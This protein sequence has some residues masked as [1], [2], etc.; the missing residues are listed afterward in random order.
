MPKNSF[1]ELIINRALKT[2]TKRTVKKT[3]KPIKLKGKKREAPVVYDETIDMD[4]NPV[5]YKYSELIAKLAGWFAPP[6]SAVKEQQETPEA[7]RLEEAH[8]RAEDLTEDEAG[9]IYHERLKRGKK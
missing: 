7:D 9:K 4:D 8:L 3:F 2:T 5:M 6:K 1:V